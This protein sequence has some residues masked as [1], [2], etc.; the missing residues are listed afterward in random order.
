MSKGIYCWNC[1]YK[2]TLAYMP[3]CDNC[4]QESTNEKKYPRWEPAEKKS[5]EKNDILGTKESS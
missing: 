1:K 2:D 3:P 5:G 4:I